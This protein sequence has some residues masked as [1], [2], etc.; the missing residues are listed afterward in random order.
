MACMLIYYHLFYAIF[1][2][3]SSAGDCH[4]KMV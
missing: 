2:A 4:I 3:Q 1:I